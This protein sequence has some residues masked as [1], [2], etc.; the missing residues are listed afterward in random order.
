M[1][2][3][4]VL[5]AAA[6]AGVRLGLE[7]VRTFLGVLGEPQHAAPVVHVAGTNGKGS[8][9]AY[10]TRILVEAGYRVG[11][12][13]SPHVEQ[14]N[15]RIQI[16]GEPITDA[17]LSELIEHI[18]RVRRQWATD[19]GLTG[20][21]LTYFEL[22][23]S[24]AF[25]AFARSSVDVAVVEVGL[26]GRLDATNV[27]S[28]VACAVPHI[29]LDH[30]AILGEDL[31]TIAAEKAGI[32]KRG[33]PVCLGPIVPEA[34]VVLEAVA[35]RLGCPVW[36]PP[37]LRREAHRDGR[38]TLH[39]PRGSV[40]PVRLGLSGVH[41]GANAMV[42]VGVVHRLIEQGF[43]VPEASIHRGLER[44][45][46]PAR[47]ETL[48]EGLVIDGAHNPDGARVLAQ[49]LRQRPRP[50]GRVLLL[51]VGHDRSP[52]PLLRP[53]A[54]HFDEIVTTRCAHPKA[55]DPTEL[56]LALAGLHPVI[57]A[58]GPVEEA[59][60]EVYA[61][62]DETVVAGSLFIAGAARSLVGAGALAGLEP[63]QGLAT[64]LEEL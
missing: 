55:W 16:D 13:L 8:V 20:D 58:G 7:R 21:V 50:R 15:E 40:G 17:D 18:D 52:V 47:L 44:A 41:Q 25:L 48:C 6:N 12:T 39:T 49:W 10:V 34:R 26:G 53:L 38:F 59:L 54:P 51:G 29:G 31:A 2:H 37:A 63:G 42:A 14:I 1:N 43:H 5:E 3:H 32:F 57:S 30:Q 61:E 19:A 45:F 27:V 62:A 24:A 33:V 4:P 22:M 46:L 35:G 9:C 64:D 28:P 56:A 11:M 23:V 36:A 60:P